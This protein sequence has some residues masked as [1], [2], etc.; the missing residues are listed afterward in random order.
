MKL[1]MRINQKL[2]F[3]MTISNIHLGLLA[4]HPRSLVVPAQAGTTRER[5]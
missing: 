3:R 2:K 4:R 5:G 1:F